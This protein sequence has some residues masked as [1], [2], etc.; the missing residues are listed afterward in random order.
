VGNRI[1][2]ALALLATTAVSASV[3]WTRSARD[4]RPP[5]AT[6]PSV[7][8]EDS[9]VESLNQCIQDRFRNLDRFGMSRMSVHSWSFYPVTPEERSAVTRLREDGWEVGFYLGGRE[10]LE[11]PGITEAEW[12]EADESSFRR[13]VSKPISITGQEPPPDLPRPW[14]LWGHARKALAA[15]D[16]ADSYTASV[17]RWSIDARPVRADRQVCLKCHDEGGATAF[18]SPDEEGGRPLRVGDALGV[19]IYVYAR[20]PK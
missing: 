6:V 8:T 11:R 15:S 5:A 1:V 12:N 13:A 17:G 16:V 3:S 14:E 9:P 7:A 4:R 10:L 2:V 20:P 18:P 19:A